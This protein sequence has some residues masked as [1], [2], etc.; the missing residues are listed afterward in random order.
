MGIQRCD[1]ESSVARKTENNQLAHLINKV[2][3]IALASIVAGT[4]IALTY[5]VINSQGKVDI[6]IHDRGGSVKINSQSPQSSEKEP[7]GC[8]PGEDKSRPEDCNS[9]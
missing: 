4:F 7:D 9:Q 3:S 2:T 1:S 8:L 6:E 5:L